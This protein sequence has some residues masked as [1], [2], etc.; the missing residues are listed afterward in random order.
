[1]QGKYSIAI[2]GEALNIDKKKIK[3]FHIGDNKLGKVK[4][5]PEKNCIQL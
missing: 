2:Q 4:Y 3:L 5:I 1:M